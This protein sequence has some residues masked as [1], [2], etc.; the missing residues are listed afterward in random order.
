MIKLLQAS[1]LLW[2]MHVK[3]SFDRARTYA[4]HQKTFLEYKPQATMICVLWRF[5]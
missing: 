5:N 1:C 4:V 3:A 2:S